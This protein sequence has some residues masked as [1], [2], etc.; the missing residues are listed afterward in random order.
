[1]DGRSYREQTQYDLL[2]NICRKYGFGLFVQYG[3]AGRAGCGL[4]G[5]GGS[6]STSSTLSAHQTQSLFV[7]GVLTLYNGHD[8]RGNMVDAGGA[9]FYS[10]SVLNQATSIWRDN[11]NNPSIRS[12][13]AYGSDGQRYRRID[14]GSTTG[15]TTTTTYIGSVERRQLPGGS[16]QWRRSVGGVVLIEHYG[17]SVSGGI[18]QASGTGTVRH[19]FSDHLGSVQVI[20]SVS[21]SS[22]TV[23]ERLDT[24]AHG[25]WRTPSPPFG[26]AGSSHTSRGFTGHEHVNGL[27]T[28]HMTWIAGAIPNDRRSAHRARAM[29]G[30][31]NGR[32]YW[33]SGGR[34][35]QPDPIITDPLNPQNWNPYSYVMNNPLNLI[36]PSGYS[37]L[38]KYWRTIVAVAISV[39][40]GG[41]SLAALQ[42]SNYWAAAGWAAGG[43]FASGAIQSNSFNGGVHG[44]FSGLAFFG[45]SAGFNHLAN[46][47]LAAGTKTMSSTGLTAAQFTGQ[48]VAHGMTGGVLAS[49]QG[50]KFGH[51]FASAGFTTGASPMIGQ[52][53][54]PMAQGTA[55]ALVGG[56]ASTMTGGKFANGAVTAAMSYAL[57]S[58]ASRGASSGEGEWMFPEGGS[59]DINSYVGEDGTIPIYTNGILG[60]RGDFRNV[61]NTEGA[62]GYFNPSRGPFADL[63]ESFGQKF[64]G[65]AGD[66]LAAGFAR[67]LVGVNH[68]LTITA[69]SQGTLTVTNAVRY[70]G[71]SV[72]GSAFVMK[73]PA[74]SHFTASRAIQGRGGTMVW[75]QPY[76]DIANIYAPSLNPLRWASG[77]GDIFCGACRHTANGLP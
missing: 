24:D 28:I 39:Y 20:G 49:V 3:Y 14:D 69:H 54:G 7:P 73:S 47:N 57:S 60:N 55:A 15:G 63:V 18:T 67:G 29:D 51:G 8:V 66:P 46:V 6:S 62:P 72:Q 33:A 16:I 21:G 70:Y 45:V 68:P 50:G 75:R 52:A 9:R 12:R 2:G 48:I 10:Y 36:D 31:S 61:L 11:I 23:L 17:D 42:A 71:L 27:D 32:L 64:F 59:T 37:F 1:M 58:A 34:M 76:G 56:T 44:A 30:P 40:T 41:A 4:S 43:G 5:V 19:Q 25:E 65:W 13:F 53:G 22:I 38:S 35:V 77:F 26:Q 74:L